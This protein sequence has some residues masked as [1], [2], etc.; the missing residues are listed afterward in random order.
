MNFLSVIFGYASPNWTQAKI[1]QM[2][3]I[4]WIC[5]NMIFIYVSICNA[6]AMTDNYTENNSDRVRL[7]RVSQTALVQRERVAVRTTRPQVN[8]NSF[9]GSQP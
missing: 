3:W 6:C 1:W 9:N 7:G 2:S 4:L 8:D 5:T